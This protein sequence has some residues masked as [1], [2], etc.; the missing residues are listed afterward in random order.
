MIKIEL[1][2]K[3]LF[4]FLVCVFS[5]ETIAQEYIDLI[6]LNLANGTASTFENSIQ[7]TTLQAISGDL[8]F[9][10]VINNSTTILTGVSFDSFR[11]SFDPGRTEESI[12]GITLKLGLNLKHNDKW[13]GTYMLLPKLA[14]DLEN[15]SQRDW[16]LGG[17]VLMKYTKSDHFNYKFGLYVN[18]EL[19]S[20]FAV[21]IFGFYYLNPSEKFEAKV[22]APLALDLNYSFTKNLRLGLNFNGQIRSY[23]INT[24][25]DNE[26]DRYLVK[27][28]NDL[29]TYFQYGMKNGVNFQVGIGRSIGRSYRIYNEKI[30]FGIPLV[31]FGDD[32]TQLNSD[33]SDSWL[34]KASI[35]YRL[36][37]GDK[38]DN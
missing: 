37:I 9:P 27:S 24:P 25:V 31:K 2:K 7:N 38:T 34:F 32:R 10:I 19:F 30:S 4:I 23:N 13:S 3:I 17:I 18:N 33:F 35:F 29:F 12:Y 20:P 22:L 14:S 5:S 26:S 1:A 16:Q 36:D 8:T 21:P 15:V 6:K 28:A 11:A